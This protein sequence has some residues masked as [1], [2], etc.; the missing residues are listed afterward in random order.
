M[1]LFLTILRWPFKDV[2]N[3]KNIVAVTP[4]ILNY[5]GE[6]FSSFS[7]KS[8]S[9]DS[10]DE[11]YDYYFKIRDLE[12]TRGNPLREDNSSD[13][14]MQKLDF[15]IKDVSETV[16]VSVKNTGNYIWDTQEV[17]LFVEG[18]GIRVSEIFLGTKRGL[19][20]ANLNRKS[21]Y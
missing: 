11:F 5:N 4:F 1:K 10:D 17:N 20:W 19:P 13:P 21:Q 2:W 8:N 7:F 15:L 6:P 18:N 14:E 9:G 12:K 16:L 3:N